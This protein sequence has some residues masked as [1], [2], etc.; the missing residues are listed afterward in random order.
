[1][2]QD[3]RDSTRYVLDVWQTGLGM[4]DRDYYLEESFA[5]T[6]AAYADHVA[7]MLERVGVGTS[8]DAQRIVALETRLARAHWTAVAN[9]DPVKTYNQYRLDELSD[10]TPGYNWQAYLD[11]SRSGR[12]G[13]ED[14]E[15][16]P[17]GLRAT[18]T[19]TP[20][21]AEVAS[22]TGR[23]ICGGRC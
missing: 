17:A 1:M 22:R 10:L 2:H 8:A 12:T 11:G 13:I 14:L 6:R 16:R 19:W 23:T 15:R 3:N 7:T 18:F 5:A 20:C 21:S 4:P 9:R